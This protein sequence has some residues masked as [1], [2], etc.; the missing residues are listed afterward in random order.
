MK[1]LQVVALVSLIA[2]ASGEQCFFDFLRSTNRARA[3]ESEVGEQTHREQL[4]SATPWKYTLFFYALF[5]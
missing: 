4:P 2:T 1:T 5:L 3:F